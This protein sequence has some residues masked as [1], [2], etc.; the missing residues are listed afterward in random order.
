M[1][2]VVLC[3]GQGTRMA[4][5][6]DRRPKPLLPVGDR[7]LVEHVLDA[8]L[9]VVDEFV[10]VVG[11]RGEDVREELGD[12]YR[13]RPITYVQQ[14]EQR[15][16]AHA[17]A[18]ARDAI[19][20]RFLVLNGDVL[21]DASLPQALGETGSTA[22]AGTRVPDPSSYGV[23]T[24]DD[25]AVTDLVEKPDEPP[26]D[27]ANVGC[28]AFEPDVFEYIDR[29]EE[30]ER[31]EYEITETIERL[32]ADGRTVAAIEYDGRWLDVGRPW[33]LL[34][35][36]E[37]VLEQLD[38]RLEGTVEEGAQIRGPV[39]IEEGA[40]VRSGAYLEGPV[41][42]RS[43]ADV[44]PNT[45]IRG[46]TVIGRNVSVGNGVEIKNSILMTDAAANHLSYVGD[47]I[48][49]A[50]ANLGA[51]TTV[52]NLRH[53]DESVR[54]TVKGDRVDTGR[55]KLGVVLGD[56]VKTGINTSLNA[57]IR[58]ET[59]TTTPPGE[60]VLRDRSSNDT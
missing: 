22:M 13:D 52:A 42:V 34:E 21:I 35:A 9:E 2:G 25:G 60:T 17:I 39:A 23:L 56:E 43:G 3:A 49:G 1:Y 33:E 28:Y 5:L 27:L 12:Q 54:M 18:Q 32:I 50:N 48:I 11:Y 4:P 41:L 29:T 24:V 55:R 26:T 19:D 45:Y 44:G 57:G 30:S 10:L 6:T 20:E 16:T 38:R 53:D 59:G 47:S 31:G 40:R 8:C 15:G 36:T 37:A 58:L 14:L 51:G 46:A 7:T